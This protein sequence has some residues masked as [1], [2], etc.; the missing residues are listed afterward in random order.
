MGEPKETDDFTR[1][2]VSLTLSHVKVEVDLTEPL[3]SVVEFERQ[4]GEVVE[5]LVHYPWTPPTCSHCHELGH[6][7]CNCLQLPSD[8]APPNPP[9]VTK[10][11]SSKT[12]TSN[13]SHNTPAPTVPNPKSPSA[14]TPSHQ[15]Q[16]SDAFLSPSK[17][18]P[19]KNLQQIYVKKKSELSNSF[20]ALNDS[21][22]PLLNNPIPSSPLA[23]PVTNQDQMLIDPPKFPSQLAHQSLLIPLL[24]HL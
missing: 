2:L 18:F 19:S 9:P 16:P 1:N 22:I 8:Y 24:D 5:V 3:P 21:S 11:P 7:V 14:R 12:K 4:S 17:P 13:P 15:K 20:Q 6:I 23:P 10:K